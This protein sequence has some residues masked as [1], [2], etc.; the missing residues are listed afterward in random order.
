MLVFFVFKFIQLP[1]ALLNLFI[2]TLSSCIMKGN[3]F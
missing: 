2:A 1:G 3:F